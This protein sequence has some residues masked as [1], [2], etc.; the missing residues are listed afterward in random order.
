M[1]TSTKFQVKFLPQYISEIF[2][3]QEFKDPLLTKNLSQKVKYQLKKLGNSLQEEYKQA[4]E[5]LKELFEKYSETTPP[6]NVS[7]GIAEKSIPTKKIKPEFTE[8]FREE[9]KEIE[10][11]EVEIHHTVFVERDFVDQS[12][13]EVVGGNIYW[14]I[15]DKLVYEKSEKEKEEE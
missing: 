15:I 1:T 14:N 9:S 5:H 11:M 12:T 8:Q 3:N 6:E 7:D 4:V 10:E 2:G 13:G